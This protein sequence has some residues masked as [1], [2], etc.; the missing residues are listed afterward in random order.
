MMSIATIKKICKS[1]IKAFGLILLDCVETQVPRFL[2]V[3]NLFHCHSLKEILE[4]VGLITMLKRL[5][6]G[7]CLRLTALL[8]SLCQLTEFQ[9]LNLTRCWQMASLPSGIGNLAVL[10]AFSADSTRLTCSPDS[11]SKFSFLEKLSLKVIGVIAHQFW[12]P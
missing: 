9:V 4:N 10:H 11:S 8:S 1:I 6:L 7:Q 2:K 12:R 3:L 5:N